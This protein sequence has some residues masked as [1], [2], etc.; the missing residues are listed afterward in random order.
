MFVQSERQKD[1]LNGFKGFYNIWRKRIDSKEK[2]EPVP[3]EEK[4]HEEEEEEQDYVVV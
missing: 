4:E 3:E 1:R 2:K